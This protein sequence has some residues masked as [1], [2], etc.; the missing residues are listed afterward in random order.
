MKKI[1]FTLTFIT[2]ITVA[3]SQII[4][5]TTAYLIDSIQA[6][7]AYYVGKPLSTLL[8]DLR[9]SIKSYQAIV[10]I[11]SLPDTISFASTLLRFYDLNTIINKIYFKQKELNIQIY[12]TPPILIPKNL[13]EEDALLY[14]T[15]W[16]PNKANFFGQY[17]L[18]D[19]RLRGL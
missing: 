8:N 19:I 18:S 11:P 15:E 9:I 2:T 6:K 14:G 1:I 12:F 7:K 17:I 10:P 3:K 4:T 16:T 13:F 5:D